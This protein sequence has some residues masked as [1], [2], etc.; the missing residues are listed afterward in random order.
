MFDLHKPAAVHLLLPIEAISR[1]ADPI[2][3]VKA[4]KKKYLPARRPRTEVVWG[5]AT[6][7][8]RSSAPRG[9]PRP[10]R[11]RCSGSASAAPAPGRPNWPNLIQ[12][13]KKG[14][15]KNSESLRALGLRH[16]LRSS[17]SPISNKKKRQTILPVSRRRHAAVCFRRRTSLPLTYFSSVSHPRLRVTTV[18]T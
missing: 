9:R 10:A 2:E 11:V 6:H 14:I 3:T 8:S 16:A 15:K 12:C 5:R 18:S 4:K 1:S 13:K 17:V 7:R